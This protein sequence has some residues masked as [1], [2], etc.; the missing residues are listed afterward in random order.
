MAPIKRGIGFRELPDGSSP[1]LGHC[2]AGWLHAK[3]AAMIR[4]SDIT[5]RLGRRL[6][7][8]KAT[9]ALPERARVGFVGRNGAGKTTLFRIIS[10]EI[11]PESGDI[12]VPRQAR[13]GRVE[14]EAPGG[15]T[16]LID[17]VLAADK[18][19]ASLLAEAETASDP[20][21]IAD[22]QTRLADIG[23]HSAPA[24]A[25]TI[26]SGLGFDTAAQKRALAEFSG[27]W[28]M[29]VALAAVLFSA[30]DLLLLDEPTN[31][32]DLEGTLWLIDYLAA[33]PS[34]LIVISHDRD[35]LDAVCDHILHLDHSKLS[36]YRGN[37]SAFERQRREAR[38]IELKH[39]KKQEE[40]RRHLQAFVD[41]FRAQAT[42]GRQAQ[43]RLKMLARM[44]P[45]TAIVDEDVL[46]FHLP[47]PAKRLSPPII[48]LEGASVG[49]DDK[50]VL[51]RLTLSISDDD[52]I[53][54]LGTNGNGKS[55]FAK[56]VA[57][58][59]SPLGGVLRRAPKLDIG[60]FAQHQ[61]DDLDPRGTA[62]S[63]I[64]ELMREAP[65]AR[66][67]ARAAQ[68]GF[69]NVKADT[70][71][72]ELSGGEKA[73][74]LMGLATFGGPHLLILDEP[75]NHLDIDSRA[76][77]IDAINDYAG[78]VILVSHDRHLIEACA[79]R[80]WLVAGGTV[81]TFDG[82][83]DDYRR[84]VLEQAAR[85]G[86]GEKGTE[87]R[88]ARAAERRETG[89]NRKNNVPL[90]KKIEAI[91][92]R[93]RKFEDLLARVDAA[94]AAPDAF[95]KDTAK[96]IELGQNRV[97][98]AKA[99]AAAEEEWLELTSAYEAAGSVSA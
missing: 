14:Q 34:T 41:R 1:A 82:D 84:F 72:S 55:T 6:L 85:E 16:S 53:A 19:R 45:V 63:H 70:A 27:G 76:A 88:P 52:R 75:T 23:A 25:A 59:L 28:R 4:F 10:D 15:P 48:A 11:A 91:E 99:L 51:T 80:L 35:L 64:A 96:A 61:I 26:L 58:R 66:I 9:A 17:F 56:L 60:F 98:L 78:A 73:R 57:G 8:D 33:Y 32:L 20:H 43:S 69:P 38:A 22:I 79:D 44:E 93:M 71:V 18:E 46:P 47:S 31:Y 54:L 95:T 77:L 21:R 83:M 7:F 92:E 87:G 49:Y 65:E 37:Y 12:L 5:Y 97:E 94:L 81:K 24:R 67:R 40:Q 50:P 30:P 39:Q 89:G 42:K 36:L 2:L 86:T 29:R 13:L 90:R 62:Y 3:S 68:M 74:L